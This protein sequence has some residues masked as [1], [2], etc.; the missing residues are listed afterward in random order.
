MF[1]CLSREKAPAI[2]KCGS[3][4]PDAREDEGAV[5]E[6]GHVDHLCKM[7]PADSRAISRARARVRVGSRK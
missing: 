5:A 6:L 2:G 7:Q 1:P 4:V 3:P